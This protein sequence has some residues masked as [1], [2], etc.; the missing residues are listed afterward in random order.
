MKFLATLSFFAAVAIAPVKADLVAKDGKYRT[1]LGTLA[2]TTGLLDT[3]T[4]NFPV[5]FFGPTDAAFGDASD[6]LS[7]LDESALANVI[8]SHAVA[9]IFTVLH[10]AA[11]GCADLM[12]LTGARVR[13][14]YKD[15]TLMINDA[16]VIQADL[17]EEEGVFHGID[18]VV[19]PG[20]FQPCDAIS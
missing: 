3:I 8:A 4:G 6:A 15:G 7:G 9:G 17:I 18:K 12:S 13:I 2:N 11:A 16:T 10:F 1:L 20:S 14:E 5:T 19:L